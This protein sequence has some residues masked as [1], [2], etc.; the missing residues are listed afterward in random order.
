LHV[1]SSW[2]HRK[3]K[4]VK[5]SDRQHFPKTY[6]SGGDMAYRSMACSWKPSTCYKFTSSSAIAERSRYR[7]G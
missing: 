7:V 3:G 6:F 2:A 4:D 1:W 5:R